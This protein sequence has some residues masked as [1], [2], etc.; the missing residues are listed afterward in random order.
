MLLAGDP[1]V[2]PETTSAKVT[3]NFNI[4]STAE[5]KVCQGSTTTG[6]KLV[7]FSDPAV[8]KT[9]TITLTNLQPST[10]YAY[11]IYGFSKACDSNRCKQDRTFT[12]ITN[13]P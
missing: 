11:E 3:F 8:G 5:V 4:D 6:C 7:A 9:H 10:L 2:A 1:T 13:A 12:F